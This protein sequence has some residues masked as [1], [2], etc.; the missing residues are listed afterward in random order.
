[1]SASRC[2]LE[3]SLHLRLT[4]NI[5]K[6][7]T[8]ERLLILNIETRNLSRFD[9]DQT[10]CPIDKI[11]QTL[12]AQ[13]LNSLDYCRLL[14]ILFGEDYSLK[15]LILSCCRKW[16]RT[17]NWSERPIQRELTEDHSIL[18]LI[19]LRLTRRCQNSHR[20]RQIKSR[21]LLTKVGRRQI[22]NHLFTRH[23]EHRSLES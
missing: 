6:I 12:N 18:Q 1:M 20:N 23:R 21:T 11:S 7:I 9:L 13:H 4:L 8:I 14:A 10:I 16:Q 2:D 17:L 15:S 22:H 5:R 3:G 19:I